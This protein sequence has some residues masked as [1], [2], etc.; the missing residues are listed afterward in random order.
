MVA[1]RYHL[2]GRVDHAWKHGSHLMSLHVHILPQFH[3]LPHNHPLH[4][5][6]HSVNALAVAAEA[7]DHVGT[8]AG[9]LG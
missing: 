7:G 3:L 4:N 2:D 8:T 1:E 5:A 9:G 6:L